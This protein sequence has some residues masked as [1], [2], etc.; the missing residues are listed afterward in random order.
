GATSSARPS[1]STLT[2]IW[3]GTCAAKSLSFIP[4]AGKLGVSPATTR[5]PPPARG[6]TPE[7]PPKQ[8]V[9]NTARTSRP[10]SKA[11]GRMRFSVTVSHSSSFEGELSSPRSLLRIRRRHEDELTVGR[12]AVAV[13]L[14]QARPPQPDST[15]PPPVH[16]AGHDIHQHPPA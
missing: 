4:E 15:R 13:F 10:A 7:R 16:A 8:P 5:V 1:E 6:A 9:I 12:A 3:P 14:G 2:W 11:A